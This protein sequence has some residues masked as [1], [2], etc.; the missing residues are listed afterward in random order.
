[1]ARNYLHRC[2]FLV[3]ISLLI[4]LIYP[5]A[6]LAQTCDPPV[7]TA[8]SVQG[9]VEVQKAGASQ[10]QAVKLNDTYCPGDT[11]RTG[12]NSRGGPCPGQ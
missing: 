5:I 9:T 4:A 10:W 8:V 2:H 3:C 7:A 11:I 12:A 6:A 1:M